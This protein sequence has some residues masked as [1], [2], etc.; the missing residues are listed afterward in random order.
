MQKHGLGINGIEPWQNGDY[1]GVVVY[2]DSGLDPTNPKW[3]R[4]AFKYFKDMKED[5]QYSATY[6]IPDKI[7]KADS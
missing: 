6:F 4:D 7:L 5:L 2:E 3:Y 1:F